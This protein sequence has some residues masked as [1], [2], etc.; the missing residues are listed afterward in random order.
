MNENKFLKIGIRDNDYSNELELMCRIIRETILYHNTTDFTDCSSCDKI[1]L[2]DNIED[3]FGYLCEIQY[4]SEHREYSK[5]S[6]FRTIRSKFIV[7]ICS[8]DEI[9]TSG[10]CEYYYIQLTGKDKGYYFTV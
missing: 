5:M 1:I 6:L 2:S 7:D 10:N 4:I 3:L 9:P 8:A